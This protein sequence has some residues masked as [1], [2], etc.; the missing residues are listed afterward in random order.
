MTYTQLDWAKDNLSPAFLTL[1]AADQLLMLSML[2]QGI[3][4]ARNRLKSGNGRDDTIATRILSA[5]RLTIYLLAGV[6]SEEETERAT[7]TI[8]NLLG[9]VLAR[10]PANANAIALLDL[11]PGAEPLARAA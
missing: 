8:R 7:R 9:Q 6:Y 4:S 5:R 1:S 11:L 10:E 3:E 2:D